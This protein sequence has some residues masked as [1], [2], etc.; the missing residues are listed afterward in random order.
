MWRPMGQTLRHQ[1]QK[2]LDLCKHPMEIKC[3]MMR[4][5][6]GSMRMQ[7]PELLRKNL[8]RQLRQASGSPLG[9]RQLCRR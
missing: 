8:C 2:E 3:E 4:Q 9:G 6:L 7:T 5:K 1:A